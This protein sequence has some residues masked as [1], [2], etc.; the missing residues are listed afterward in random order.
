MLVKRLLFNQGI[1]VILQLTYNQLALRLLAQPLAQK[2]TTVHN[3]G[4][5]D[6]KVFSI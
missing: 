6:R 4:E 1:L 5:K 3:V 2:T